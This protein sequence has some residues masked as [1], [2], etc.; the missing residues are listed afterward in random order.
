LRFVSAGAR[1]NITTNYT[2]ANS[3]TN[4]EMPDDAINPQQRQQPHNGNDDYDDN[5]LA[6]KIYDELLTKIIIEV[7]CGL[8]RAAKTGVLPYSD[9]MAGSVVRKKRQS[10]DERDDPEHDDADAK[11]GTAKVNGGIG[12]T[13]AVVADVV[14]RDGADE[15]SNA[16]EKEVSAN[17]NTEENKLESRLLV[18]VDE[19]K[20]GSSSKKRKLE[21]L[22]ANCE[23][24]KAA[25]TE[26]GG[27]SK[28]SE[29]N[30]KAN[31]V[32]ISIGNSNKHNNKNNN[33]TNSSNNDSGKPDLDIWGRPLQKEPKYQVT[34]P[35]CGRNASVP[36][37]TQHLEKC[38]GFSGRTASMGSTVG[39]SS[40]S[41]GDARANHKNN[42]NGRNSLHHQSSGS[43]SSGAASSGSAAINVKGKRK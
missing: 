27:I 40:T 38:L 18:D 4:T 32:D 12:A 29:N 35:N 23:E 6:E 28:N 16:S 26:M 34:C 25:S 31:G 19:S 24:K 8:H 41:T 43:A 30:T 37:F 42:T 21:K 1:A 13:A 11:L 9:V 14:A 36:R 39:S 3:S 15:E 7:T 33:N 20:S 5:I 17:A 22:K 10:K 2:N